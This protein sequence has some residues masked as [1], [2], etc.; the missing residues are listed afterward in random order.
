MELRPK[1]RL[2][3]AVAWPLAAFVP[4]VATAQN[5]SI[6]GR[7]SSAQTLMGPN[8]AI[9]ANL[10]KQVGSNLFQSFGKFGLSTGEIATFSGPVTTQY[11]IGRVTG[12]A[13]SNVNGQIRSTITGASLYLVNPSGIVF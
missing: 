3:L 2:A 4:Q 9:G 13:L 1:V 8:Y 11:V 7:F 5:I 10:G 12:G 6:D